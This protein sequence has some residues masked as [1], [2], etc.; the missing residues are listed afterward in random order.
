[1]TATSTSFHFVFETTPEE[2]IE[3][4]LTIL[5]EA[6]TRQS[7]WRPNVP[8]ILV[9]A[10]SGAIGS[11]ISETLYGKIVTF[12][13]PIACSALLMISSK[14]TRIDTARQRI[15]LGLRKS[16]DE[17]KCHNHDLR[18]DDNG[19]VETCPCGTDTRNWAAVR[20]THETEALIVLET[21]NKC[22]YA[23]PKRVIPTTELQSLRDFIA[24]H[25]EKR[26][27]TAT[28]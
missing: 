2:F 15:V 25:V 21:H 11:L 27:T 17:K 9:A 23:I 22:F 3:G 28:A 13:V 5:H 4:A 19:F 1:M 10:I 16:Y 12:L 14:Q 7:K 8:L 20:R 18:L 24:Q 26:S 6:I